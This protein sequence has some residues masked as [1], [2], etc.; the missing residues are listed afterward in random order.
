MLY[1][2]H[3]LLRLE[4]ALRR[5]LPHWDMPPEADLKLLSISENATYSVFDPLSARRLVIRMQRPDYHTDAEIESELLW[6]NALRQSGLVHTAEPLRT[7]DGQWLVKVEDQDIT[8]RVTAFS[9]VQ[10]EEPALDDDLP[11]W[12]RVLGQINARLHQQARHWTMPEGFVRKHWCYETL[13][14][15]TPH[16]GDWRVA[17]GLGEDGIA[18][19]ETVQ[20][21]LKKVLEA[22]GD[23][24]ERYGLVHC[25][26]R[27]ANLLVDADKLYVVDFDDSGF[28]WFLYDFAACISF[29][30]QDPRVPEFL[31]AWLEGY[32]SVSPL[33]AQEAEIIPHFIMLRR[34]QLTAWIAGHSETPMAQRMGIPYAQGTVELGRQY[35][36]R[37][38]EMAA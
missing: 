26:M 5:A 16:W 24:P 21:E 29:I 2:P 38:Q 35:L 30:E 10:G 17:E 7:K 33:S 31:E 32:R 4:G 9:F 15:S 14:G 18:L 8:H 27:L 11:K 36:A 28:S 34:M 6:V 22:Y 13:I 1:E 25:D 19:L 37:I 3:F 23:S 12:Y 20:L